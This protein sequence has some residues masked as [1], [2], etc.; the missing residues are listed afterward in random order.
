MVAHF[1]WHRRD[2]RAPTPWRF[3]RGWNRDAIEPALHSL[4]ERAPNFQT[5]PEAMIPQNGWMID[6]VEDAVDQ[7]S[8]GLRPALAGATEQG[9]RTCG[10]L[11]PWVGPTAYSKPMELSLTVITLTAQISRPFNWSGRSSA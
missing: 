8:P 1:S 2:S 7:E 3:I 4:V 11:V 6:G 10:A 5:P 9:R